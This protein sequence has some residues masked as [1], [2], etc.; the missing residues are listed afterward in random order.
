MEGGPPLC[1]LSR[2]PTPLSFQRE[3]VPAGAPDGWGYPHLRVTCHGQAPPKVPKV[4]P[5][6]RFLVRVQ[7]RD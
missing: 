5:P 7:V 2:T 6:S 4:A 3:G 1:Q